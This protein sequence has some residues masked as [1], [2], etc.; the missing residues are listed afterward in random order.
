MGPFGNS[1]SQ[2]GSQGARRGLKLWPILLFGLYFG[3]YYFSHSNAAS[4]TGRKQLLDTSAEE[5]AALGLQSY[6]EILQQSD[7]VRTG[8]VRTAASS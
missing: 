7:V 4:F 1:S 3:Y 2:G 8:P 6:K 5:E